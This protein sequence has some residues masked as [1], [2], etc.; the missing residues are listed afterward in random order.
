MRLT[1][2][3][4]VVSDQTIH[5]LRGSD[6]VQDA[7]EQMIKHDVSA[8]VVV[9][10]DDKLA[11][12]V[13]ERDMTRRVVARNL[14]AKE[15]KLEAIMSEAPETLSPDD[16]AH[17][18]LARMLQCG[19]RH[20]PVVENGRAVGMVSMRILQRAIATYSSTLGL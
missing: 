13:T 18:A 16:L 5:S 20:L 3:P 15:T 8:I 6:T 9:G 1:I 4:D 10:D 19:F 14:Q 2:I 11:G 17:E 12:I 7:A